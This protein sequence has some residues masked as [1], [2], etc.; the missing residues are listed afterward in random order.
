LA[1]VAILGSGF[2]RPG[3]RASGGAR[4]GLF[5]EV[6]DQDGENRRRHDQEERDQEDDLHRDR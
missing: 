1:G 5:L 2:P 4:I 3:I 6:R